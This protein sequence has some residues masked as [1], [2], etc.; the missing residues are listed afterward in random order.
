MMRV[1]E[2]ARFKRLGGVA[3]GMLL[4]GLGPSASA[5][6]LF[7]YDHGLVQTSLWTHHYSSDAKYNDHQNLIGVELHSTD[8][9]LAGAAWLKNSFEQPTWYFYAGRE[10]T[11]WRPRHDVDV[12]AKLTAGGIRG[13]D[14][15]KQDNIAFNHY[16]IAPAI[17]PAVGAR[18]GRF[19]SDVILFGTAGMMLT[20]G[21]RF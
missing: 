12:R 17:L 13:Y 19:E 20:A 5:D 2:Q 21:T 8:R 18:W 14:G 4:V 1:L 11:L 10:F 7:S 15:D 3:L 16:G 9:W 6:G